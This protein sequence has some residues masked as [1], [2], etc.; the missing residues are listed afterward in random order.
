[1]KVS[2]SIENFTMKTKAV[3]IHL[4]PFILTQ[5]INYI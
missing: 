1:M 2:E 4:I 3:Q 5:I